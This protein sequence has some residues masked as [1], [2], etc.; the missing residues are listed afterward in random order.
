M[1]SL[2]KFFGL[3]LVAASAAVMLAPVAQASPGKSPSVTTPPSSTKVTICHRTHATTNPYVRITVAQSSI[4][5]AANKHGG[6]KHDQWPSGTS[7]PSP[8]VYNPSYSYPASQKKWGDIIPPTDVSGNPLGG[9][10]SS[11]NYSGA[12][13]DIYNGTGSYAGM[14]GSM[15]AAAFYNLEVAAGEAPADV[16]TDLDEQAADENAAELSACG[17]AFAGCN[18]TAFGGSATTISATTTT[19]AGST[20]TVARSTATTVV[21]ATTTTLA[22]K[23]TLPAGV[24]LKSGKAAL[25]GKVWID[26][27]RNNKKDSTEKYLKGITVT[28]TGPNGATLTTTTDANGYYLFDNVDPGDWTVVAKLSVS[29]LTKVYDST[30]AADWVSKASVTQGTVASL[31]FAAAPSKT[32]S[33]S[34]STSMPATGSGSTVPM[35]IMAL[36][37]IAGGFV[38]LFGIKRRLNIVD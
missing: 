29:S 1:K 34:A 9:G 18:P 17:G 3:T 35:S 25:A 31:E 22:T 11:V 23:S 33:A 6:S 20:T 7:K 15:T 32:S 21:G 12:G 28:A 26:A 4:G 13:I 38:A 24:T 5:N 19:V 16:L 30:G 14:C 36:A 37:L 2:T 8:N 27:T 10:L